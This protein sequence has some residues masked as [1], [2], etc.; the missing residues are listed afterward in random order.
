METKNKISITLKEV[1]LRVIIFIVVAV[2]V[3]TTSPTSKQY[4]NVIGFTISLL[5]TFYLRKHFFPFMTAAIGCFLI[6]SL[7]EL[8]NEDYT[9]L[10]ITVKYW[11][12]GNILFPI[13][14]ITFIFQLIFKYKIVEKDEDTQK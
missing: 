1:I 10:P 5:G 12:M 13:G 3:E 7:T 6:A 4:L 11:A 14:I 9:Y 2:I 8:W